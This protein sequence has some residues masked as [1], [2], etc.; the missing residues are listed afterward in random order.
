MFKKLTC[1]D[2]ISAD[3]KFEKISGFINRAKLTF[4]CNK[5]PGL[6]EEVKNDM[7]F[8]NRII[9]IKFKNRITVPE[10]KIVRD[11]SKAIDKFYRPELS[12]ILNWALEGARRYIKNNKLTYKHE[13]TFD[14]WF[15]DDEEEN[16]LKDFINTYYSFQE[17]GEVPTGAVKGEYIIYCSQNNITPLSPKYFGMNLSKLG[18]K[19]SKYPKSPDFKGMSV[20]KGIS[21]IKNTWNINK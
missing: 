8:W 12:G 17:D 3:R 19:R 21:S 13:D 1:G 16:P 11:L 10:D 6:S 9:L 4:V 14:L 20:Y 18:I 15:E 5:L 2:I 7:Q